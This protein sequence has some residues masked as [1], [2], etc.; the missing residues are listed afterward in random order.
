MSD[1]NPNGTD[2]KQPD[3][4]LN[5]WR[6]LLKVAVAAILYSMVQCAYSAFNA[7]VDWSK[8]PGM[9]TVHEVLGSLKAALVLGSIRGC[10]LAVMAVIIVWLGPAF[11]AILGPVLASAMKSTVRFVGEFS[12]AMRTRP[13]SSKDCPGDGSGGDKK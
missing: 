8:H 10:M 3:P 6:N 5:T 13:G 7:H 11:W 1:T 2:P 9:D 4:I 12:R